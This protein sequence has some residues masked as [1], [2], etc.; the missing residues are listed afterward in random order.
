MHYLLKIL[1][2]EKCKI[3]SDHKILDF[4]CGRGTLVHLLCQD[5]YNAEGCDVKFKEGSHVKSLED[6]GL[7]KKIRVHDY[8]LPYD[9]NMF[10]YVVSETVF[11]HIQNTDKTIAEIYQVLKPGGVALHCFPAKYGIIESHVHLPFA[12]ILKFYPYLLFW[13]L[14]GFRYFSQVRFV[15]KTAIGYKSTRI[16][17]ILAN[18]STTSSI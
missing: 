11:E 6:Q 5:G 12:S 14:L 1:E 9:D 8:R 2:H 13:A 3:T 10:D 16:T 18:T 15:E 7:I 17:V 4:G